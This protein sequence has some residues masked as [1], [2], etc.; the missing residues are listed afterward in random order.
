MPGDTWPFDDPPNLAVISLRSIVFDGAPVLYVTH[1][2]DD[3]CWQFL[4]LGDPD[5]RDSCVVGLSEMWARDVS[6]AELS[7]LPLGWHAWRDTASSP[8]QRGPNPSDQQ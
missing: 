2:L 3:H 5:E 8:W 4:G 7:D 6:L 1:D